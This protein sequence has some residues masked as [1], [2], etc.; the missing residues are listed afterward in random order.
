LNYLFEA[1]TVLGVRVDLISLD[2]LVEYILS[3]VQNQAKSIISNVNVHAINIAYRQPWFKEFINQ[4]EV[5]FC[6]GFG[7]KW[8]ASFL[9]GKVLHRLSPPDWFDRL[10]GECTDQG[11]SMFFLGTTQN[12]VE[13]AAI[14]VKEKFPNLKIVGIHHGFFDKD[15]FCTENQE[16]IEKIN[17][18]QPDILLVGFGMPTQEKWIMENF[19]DLNTKV[20][21]PVGAFFDY[22]SSEVVRA[23]KWMTDHG[24]EWLGRLIIEPGRLWKRYIIGNPIFLW[25]VFMQKC[26]I[27]KQ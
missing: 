10:A 2:E 18:A 9:S 8:A 27:I 13:K 22:L 15:P 26:N 11:I 12:S 24:L 20:I 14:V 17:S 1:T 5:V 4:S 16:V 25:R 6:D 3:V 23:P 21:L 7:V 19:A